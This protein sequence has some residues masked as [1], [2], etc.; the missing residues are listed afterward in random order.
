MT[1][2]SA[3]ISNEQSIHAAFGALGFVSKVVV[4]GERGSWH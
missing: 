2:I 4:S 3:A 1:K